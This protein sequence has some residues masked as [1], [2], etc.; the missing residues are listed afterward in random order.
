MVNRLLEAGAD[1]ESASFHDEAR[2]LCLASYQGHL[3]VVEMLLA[4][5]AHPDA[6]SQSG[7]TALYMACQSGYLAVVETLLAAG[8]NIDAP[9]KNGATPLFAACQ[10]AHLAERPVGDPKKKGKKQ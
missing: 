3:E 1:I 2:A 4:A 10:T 7:T 9:N 5:G 6:P 8:A